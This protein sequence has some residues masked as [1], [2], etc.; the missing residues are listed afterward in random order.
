MGIMSH[1]STDILALDS[2]PKSETNEIVF[3][4]LFRIT[5]SNLEKTAK[6]YLEYVKVRVADTTVNFQADQWLRKS[7]YSPQLRVDLFTERSQIEG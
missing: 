5:H 2:T 6:W 3:L 4:L 7:P 1:R